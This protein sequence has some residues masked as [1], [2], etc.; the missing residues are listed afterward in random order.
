L[1]AV[2]VVDGDSPEEG[3]TVAAMVKE[4]FGVEEVI[5]SGISPAIGIHAGP[6]AIGLPFY[7]TD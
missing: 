4:R 7:A 2:A 5:R 3:D 6:G 1:E